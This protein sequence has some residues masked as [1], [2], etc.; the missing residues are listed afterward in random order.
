MNNAG[1]ETFLQS[2]NFATDQIPSAI[3]IAEQFETFIAEQGRA[4]PDQAAQDQAATAE[5]VWQFSRRLIRNSAN[6]ES[7]FL[8]LFYYC[9]F[10]KA[11]DMAAAVFDLLD[12][13]EVSANLFRRVAEVFGTGIR[14][15]I[16]AGI[17]EAPYGLPTPDK[18]AWLH[19]VIS[20]L[21]ARV[22]TEAC[23]EFLSPSLRDLP[24]AMY[25]A[26]KKMFAE[27]ADIDDYLKRRKDAFVA[28]LDECRRSGRPFFFQEIT[29]EVLEFIRNHPEIGGGRRDGDF[30]YET[31]I[32][33]KTKEFLAETD[34]VMRRYYAC[35]C[36]WARDAVKNGDVKTE[37]VFCYC[38]GGF[39][40][41]SWE[42]VLGRP[43]KVKVVESVLAGNERCRFRIRLE[44]TKG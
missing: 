22:G 6:S 32:P 41:K 14:D 44:G 40:K 29:G 2:V 4:A 7:A 27:S 43:V 34:P 42:H 11:P 1:F 19:P 33:W 9:R 36:P 37:P 3:G 5:T 31:K 35:H 26:D 39:H 13:G 21:E 15:E 18:P 16:F 28:R 8:A 24:D 25:E 17:G 30:I 10:I 20:R 12:G 23:R 38:S